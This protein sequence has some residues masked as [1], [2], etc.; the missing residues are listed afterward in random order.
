MSLVMRYPTAESKRRTYQKHQ[1]PK[2][3]NSL[4][5]AQS[6]QPVTRINRSSFG[7]MTTVWA[8]STPTM[9]TR[10][11]LRSCSLREMKRWQR[12]IITTS[13]TSTRCGLQWRSNQSTTKFASMP[14]ASLAPPTRSPQLVTT[15]AFRYG[16]S[17]AKTRVRWH[18]WQV[19]LA[20]VLTFRW[21]TRTWLV[22]I[23][24]VSS[25]CGTLIAVKF[26]ERVAKHNL[27]QLPASKRTTKVSIS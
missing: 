12:V 11:S 27:S 5:M 4:P 23:R 6:S 2:S 21:V 10:K 18:T 25:G 9:S 13:W 15:E 19:G 17:P 24:M 8:K 22:G 26:Q 1:R 14:C 3:C 16:T 20:R 7:T